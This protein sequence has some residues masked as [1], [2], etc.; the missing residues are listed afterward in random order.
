MECQ[1][2]WRIGPTPCAFPPTDKKVAY[3]DGLGDTAIDFDIA[4]PRVVPAELPD[5]ASINVIECIFCH[6][7]PLPLFNHL[8]LQDSKAANHVEWPL[9]VLRGNGSL[10]VVLISV[11]TDK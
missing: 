11:G 9:I 8:L 3:L 7:F 2:S 10:Y 6:P 4:P 5:D 1:H